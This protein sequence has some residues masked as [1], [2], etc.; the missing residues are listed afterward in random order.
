VRLGKNKEAAILFDTELLRPAAPGPAASSNSST[1]AEGLAGPPSIGG[2][3][4]LGHTPRP[5]WS[6]TET[7]TDP[8][9]IKIGP[10]P[11]DLA[12]TTALHQWHRIISLHDRRR[13]NPRI[14][15]L[16]NLQRPTLFHRTVHIEKSEHPLS[17]LPP[18]SQKNERMGVALSVHPSQSI[19]IS[20]AISQFRQLKNQ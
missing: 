8:D 2:R 14:S 19:M 16:P 20:A 9:Q 6:T 17:M 3:A 7:F 15:R 1:P 13:Q 12:T 18:R 5:G 10:L 11:R 4:A